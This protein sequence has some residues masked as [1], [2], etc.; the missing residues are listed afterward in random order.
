MKRIRSLIENNY[1]S[2][3]RIDELTAEQAVLSATHKGLKASLASLFYQIDKAQLKAPYDGV[4]FERLVSNGDLVSAGMPAFTVINQYEQEVVI[5]IPAQLASQLV[6]SD[7]LPV[8]IDNKLHEA[9]IIAIG[10]QIDA[11]NRTV[12]L[13]LK[14]P[15][16]LGNISGLI[17]KVSIPQTVKKMGFWIP[18]TALTDGIR[19][20]WN[21]YLV[22]STASGNSNVIVPQT[23]DVEH[24]TDTQAFISGIETQEL[25]VVSSGLHRY[26]PGQIVRIDTAVNAGG[27]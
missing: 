20:Q 13:R 5:G 21:I 4:I 16:S 22:L 9:K 18:L 15:E 6:T 7:I 2:E 3:Q 27:E 1:A 12:Q 17:A 10:Q 23:V 26:V 8:R 19:G 24:T 11:S 25:K 14:L